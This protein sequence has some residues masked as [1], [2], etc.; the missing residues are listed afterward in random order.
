SNYAATPILSRT[1]ASYDA[2]EYIPLQGFAGYWLRLANLVGTKRQY[3]LD[4]A[5]PNRL[6]FVRSVADA[7][8][9]PSRYPSPAEPVFDRARI[10]LERSDITQPRFL[11]AHILPPHDPYLPPPP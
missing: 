1:L 2:V 5:L 3:I 8:I 9:W 11:W 6:G 7:L 4:A 10:L